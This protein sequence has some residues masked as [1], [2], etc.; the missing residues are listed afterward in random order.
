MELVDEQDQVGILGGFLD[1]SLEA[2]FEITAVFGAGHHRGDV[3]RE[4]AFFGQGGGDGAGG[5]PLR[6]AFH[7][8]RFSHPR[9][10]DEHGVVLFS[11]P[12]DFND[13]GDFRVPAHHRVQFPVAGGLGEVVGELFDVQFLVLIGGLFWALGRL[14]GAFSLRP[15][16]RVEQPF[17]FHESQQSAVIYAVG[18]E[19]DLSVTFRGAAQGQQE[20]LGSRRAAFQAGG[21]H[22]GD[23]QYVLGLP[24]KVDMLHFF[25]GDGFPRED[26]LVDEG[27]DVGRFDPQAL[28]RS[29]RGI[30]LLADDAQE[31]MVGADSVTAGAHGFL[32]RIFDDLIELFCYFQLHRYKN[33]EFPLIN[34]H[35]PDSFLTK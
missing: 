9:L 35:A 8:G 22:H 16:L 26:A 6:D 25:V 32:P 30:L 7:N 10:S 24:G 20:M 19:I 2:L 11:P 23:A 31:Q 29:E 12:Q 15:F 5:D 1:D 21:F 3:Q 17:V 13:A 28:Q 34:N 33:S 18:A 27:F 4:N 14:F